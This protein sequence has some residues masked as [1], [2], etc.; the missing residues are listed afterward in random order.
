M[1]KA[2]ILSTRTEKAGIVVLGN[3]ALADRH[4]EL[5]ASSSARA[6]LGTA[7]LRNALGRLV[8]TPLTSIQTVEQA[9]AE[10]IPEPDESSSIPLEEQTRIIHAM[11]EEQYRAN[12]DT[13]IPILGNKIPRTA[14]K[15]EKGRHMVAQW[16]KTIENGS[17]RPPGSTD[18]MGTFDFKW[19]WREL[20][21]EHLRR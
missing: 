1:G 16:L 17:A 8:R 21:I 9:M 11:M 18:P 2:L 15:T 20:G 3:V 14:V 5:S 12:L 19:M 10:P 6:R 13:P 4:V 7:M